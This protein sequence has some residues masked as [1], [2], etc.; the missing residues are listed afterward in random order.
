MQKGLP[1][2]SY[3]KQ[4]F[5]FFSNHLQFSIIMFYSL[6]VFNNIYT[7]F[8]ICLLIIVPPSTITKM[9]RRTIFVQF[10]TPLSASMMVLGSQGT[11]Y[12]LLYKLMNKL[13]VSSRFQQFPIFSMEKLL[14][15]LKLRSIANSN[16]Y[17]HNSFYPYSPCLMF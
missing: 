9:S 7:Y 16:F 8:C 10:T 6:K 5:T 14:V 12:Y 13:P 1:G 11:N 3:I 15:I 4:L 2:S 17:F